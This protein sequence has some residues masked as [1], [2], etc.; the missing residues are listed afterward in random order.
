MPCIWRVCKSAGLSAP[1]LRAMDIT[2]CWASPL[3]AVSPLERPSWF[4]AVDE[5]ITA[6]SMSKVRS[7]AQASIIKIPIAS[8]RTYPLASASIVLHRLSGDSIPAAK[9]VAVASTAMIE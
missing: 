2:A 6:Q 9:K 5:I 4:T 3:G 1:A 8:P 7:A